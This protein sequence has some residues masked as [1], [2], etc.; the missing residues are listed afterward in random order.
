[1]STT[2]GQQLVCS[3]HIRGCKWKK[4]STGGPRK[5]A[6]EGY[7]LGSKA[8]PDGLVDACHSHVAQLLGATVR[9]HNVT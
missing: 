5:V 9:N 2:C 4:K 3:V 6:E 8:L 1:M 7:L